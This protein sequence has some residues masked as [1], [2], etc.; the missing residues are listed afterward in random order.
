[1]SPRRRALLAALAAVVAGAALLGV[2]RL[3]SQEPARPAALPPLVPPFGRVGFTVND[4][5][6]LHC[7]LLAE[8]DVTRA[9]GMQGM[10][11][12]RGYDAMVFA[13]PADTTTSFINH[14]VPI[15]LSIGWYDA[16]GA[17]VHHTT[18]AACPSGRACP[19]YSSPR[20]YRYAVETPA[21]ALAALG[22]TAADATLR[23]ASSCAA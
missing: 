9:Q 3:A 13:F 18:M 4:D 22:L 1:M 15:D 11:D 5:V 19:T 7:A 21:G 14:F 23:L 17:L 6:A 16:G 10:D 2:S 20:P 8:T 12:L